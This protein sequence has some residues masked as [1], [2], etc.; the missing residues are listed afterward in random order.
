[1]YIFGLLLRTF[2]WIFVTGATLMLTYIVIGI[3]L[4]LLYIICRQVYRAII[5]GKSR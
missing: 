5:D 1:M 4:I 2:E 3:P